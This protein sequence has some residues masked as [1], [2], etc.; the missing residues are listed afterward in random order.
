MANPAR[1]VVAGAGM[2]GQAH[3]DRI[4]R[5]PEALLVGIVD[6]APAVA[7]KAAALGVPCS[8]DLRSMLNDARPDGVVIAL[9]NQAHFA[10][11]M[12]AVRAG[13]AILMEKPVCDTLEQAINRAGAKA[14]NKGFEAAVTA[15]EMV[16]LLG[17][18]KQ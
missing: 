1:I 5:E 15:V 18:L 10:A 2:I 14:G 3:I 12:A 13:V 16:N 7:S 6:T 9:P 11:G 4:L 17:K 8:G